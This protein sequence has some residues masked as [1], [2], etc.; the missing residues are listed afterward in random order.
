MSSTAFIF[1]GQGSQEVGM[2]RALA[3]AFPTARAVFEEVDDALSAHLSR[4]IFEGPADD[5]NLTANTQPALMTVGVAVA[6]VLAEAGIDAA[7]AGA[8]RCVAGHSLGEYAALTAAGALSLG[9]TARLLRRRG[10]AMQAAVPVGVGAM[11]ALIGIDLDG[12]TKLVEAA[13]EGDVLACANDNGAG[14]VVISGSKAAVDR[15]I[16]RVSEFGGRKAMALAVSA[17][18][19]CPLMQ[20]AADA[21]AEALSETAIA[22]PAAPVIANVTAAPE[23]EPDRIRQLLVDQV[24]GLVRWRESVERMTADGVTR[25]VE[26]GAGKVL[27]GINKRIAKDIP[28]VSVGTPDDVEALVK[29]L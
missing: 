29:V 3:D 10:E 21:M 13:A 8:V 25:F 16:A 2:G 20:P 9:D 5:L 1:P 17:P 4:L 15:A 14:Q 18:F 28:T 23:S 12:A 26:L 24:T 7:K 11:A 19:H 27:A 22:S 6:R